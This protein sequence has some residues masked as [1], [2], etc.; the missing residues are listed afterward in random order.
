ML[1]IGTTV[2]LVGMFAVVGVVG[3]GPAT[4]TTTGGAKVSPLVGSWVGTVPEL[5]GVSVVMSFTADGKFTNETVI[6]GLPK[7]PNVTVDGGKQEGTYTLADKTLT[8]TVGGKEKKMTVKEL[9]DDKLVLANPEGVEMTFTK[10][11]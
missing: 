3:C 2:G 11:K 5:K 7:E 8:A 10:K 1:R 6:E 9:T 4:T